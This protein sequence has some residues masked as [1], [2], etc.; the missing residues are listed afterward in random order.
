MQTLDES[1]EAARKARKALADVHLQL[2]TSR[3]AEVLQT[4]SSLM[5][6]LS[7]QI[8]SLSHGPSFIFC[9]LDAGKT[10]RAGREADGSDDTFKQSLHGNSICEEPDRE[11]QSDGKRGSKPG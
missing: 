5:L 2:N 10:D 1:E 7:V 4:L 11:E 6:E 3:V 9:V 8:L